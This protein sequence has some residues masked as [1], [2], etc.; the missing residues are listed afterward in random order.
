MVNGFQG[1]IESD[2]PLKDN[3]ADEKLKKYL[4]ACIFQ[5]KF[6]SNKNQ[7]Q[8]QFKTGLGPGPGKG[9]TLSRGC[10][11]SA[12]ELSSSVA[13]VPLSQGVGTSEELIVPPSHEV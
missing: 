3:N 13:L 7:L 9:S 10:F 5:S 6:L 12:P 2:E 4:I 11:T 8:Y 1:Q